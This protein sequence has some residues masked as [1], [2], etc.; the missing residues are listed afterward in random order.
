[1]PGGDPSR[2]A[3]HVAVAERASY[4]PSPTESYRFCY[5]FNI[6]LLVTKQQHPWP[7]Q[8]CVIFE[9]FYSG[10]MFFRYALAGGH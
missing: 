4:D 2:P 3:S 5:L 10:E 8:I 6:A 1:M 7:S 9:R